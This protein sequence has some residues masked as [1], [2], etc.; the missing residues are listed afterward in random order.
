MM[1]RQPCLAC[2]VI[3]AFVL[4]FLPVQVRASIKDVALKDLAAESDLIVVARVW[5]PGWSGF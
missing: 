1:S 5:S 2:K 4:L 3:V